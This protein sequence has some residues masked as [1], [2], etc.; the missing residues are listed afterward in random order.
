MKVEININRKKLEK[1][2]GELK[3][4]WGAA[5][6]IDGFNNNPCHIC[7]IL[8]PKMQKTSYTCPQEIYRYKYLISKITKLL[9]Q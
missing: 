8:F 5:C 1:Y 3:L 6:F 9:N 2:L 7:K 4:G